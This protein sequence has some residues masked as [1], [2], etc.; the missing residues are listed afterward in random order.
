MA[1]VSR[2]DELILDESTP[3]QRRALFAIAVRKN[4][5]FARDAFLRFAGFVRHTSLAAAMRPFLTRFRRARR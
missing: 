1:E 3:A 4:E 5:E 2:R